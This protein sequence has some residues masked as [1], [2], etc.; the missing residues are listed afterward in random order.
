MTEMINIPTLIGS[1]RARSKNI[2]TSD[3]N[4]N[5]TN[6]QPTPKINNKSM[7]EL[8]NYL[9]SVSQSQPVTNIEKRY[10][11]STKNLICK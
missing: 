8:Y 6:I 1:T 11:E 4:I 5:T 9:K 10:V 2:M 3:E 7:C